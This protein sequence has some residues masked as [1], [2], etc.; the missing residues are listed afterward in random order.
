VNFG[1][2]MS[3]I[4]RTPITIPKEVT[5]TL[6]DKQIIIKGPKGELTHQLPD[7]IQIDIKDNI[8]TVK[9]SDDTK[10]ARSL[11]GLTRALIANMVTG[12]TQGYTK[13][14]ELVGTGYRVT[15]Q[16]NKLIISV[17]YSHPVEYQAPQGIQ[18][19]VE[20]NNIIKVSGID[21]QLVGQIAAEIRAIRKPEPYKGKGIR[22]QGEHIRRKAGKAA[23]G[24]GA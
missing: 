17:G 22:Y 23:K 20:G 12:V 6:N 11:H 8:L 14:L 10:M 9:R 18:L 2:S 5:V 7:L 15:K 13:V 19:D 3:R 4:G 1:K 21:K 16:A 24:T